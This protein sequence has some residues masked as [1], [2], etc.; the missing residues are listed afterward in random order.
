MKLQLLRIY[1]DKATD[2]LAREDPKAGARSRRVIKK[3][4][5]A[6]GP[7]YHSK[8]NL[9]GGESVSLTTYN[10]DS[11][12]HHLS[13]GTLSKQPS[14][15]KGLVAIIDQVMTGLPR[16]I[17][18]MKENMAQIMKLARSYCDLSDS[19]SE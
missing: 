5:T 15:Q 9:D 7:I 2:P 3:Q 4:V 17:K 8:I 10:I 1:M 18:V 6:D 14:N 11:L 13:C 12:H 16:T 19:E